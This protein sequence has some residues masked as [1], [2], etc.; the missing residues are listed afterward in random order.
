M[1]HAGIPAAAQPQSTLLFPPGRARDRAVQRV[2]EWWA[3]PDGD[4]SQAKAGPSPIPIPHV[5]SASPGHGAGESHCAW[6]ALV[7]TRR[8]RWCGSERSLLF[9]ACLAGCG[10]D[11]AGYGAREVRAVCRSSF[12]RP[13][14]TR[15]WE[16]LVRVEE[17]ASAVSWLGPGRK[18]RRDARVRRGG[19]SSSSSFRFNRHR[20]RGRRVVT[21]SGEV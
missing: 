13:F 16:R 6:P 19:S 18:L 17:S 2:R 10:L 5:S 15:R 14:G 7:P 11:L 21:V 20:K 9:R 4:L 12:L 8:R 3:E 1:G